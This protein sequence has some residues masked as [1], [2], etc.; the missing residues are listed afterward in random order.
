MKVEE[1]ISIS[2][3]PEAIFAVYQDVKGWNKWDPDTKEAFLDGPFAV[4]TMGR[5][6]PT[7]GRGVPMR[8]TE[9]VPGR[10]FTVEGWIPMFRM[11]FDH[12]LIPEGTSTRAVHRVSFSGALTFLFGPIVAKQVREGLPKTML[13]LKRYV[14][15]GGL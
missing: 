4:G 10:S 14:E 15:K 12:E 9:L 5:I 7:K 3:P 6:V 1:S 13:S 11:K 2:A 8:V